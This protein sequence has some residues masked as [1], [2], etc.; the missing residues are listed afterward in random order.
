M[1]ATEE[2]NSWNGSRSL[3]RERVQP[4]NTADVDAQYIK[5]IK[6]DAISFNGRLD[7]QVYIDWQLA[8]DRY[9]CW[10]DMSETRKIQFAMMKLTGQAGQYWE[11]LR[12]L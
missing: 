8:M 5:S 6:V 1:R 10:H 7:P 3:R 11:I 4:Y 9:F 2:E 12:G